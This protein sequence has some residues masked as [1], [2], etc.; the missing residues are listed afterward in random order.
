MP[1]WSPETSDW[2]PDR[3]PTWMEV[4]IVVLFSVSTAMDL[5]PY[6]EITWAWG[7]V[8]F[9]LCGFGMGPAGTTSSEKRIGEGFETSASPGAR[10]PSCSSPSACGGRCSQSTSRVRKSIAT[11]R[12]CVL[13]RRFPS[14]VPRRRRR[15]RR[16]ERDVA[17]YSRRSRHSLNGIGSPSG[18]GSSDRSASSSSELPSGSEK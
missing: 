10:L 2:F 8:G 15:N 13:P 17:N 11:S 3:P 18:S 6:D 5:Y 9:V 16:V 7:A 14:R 4:G 1:S 12:G